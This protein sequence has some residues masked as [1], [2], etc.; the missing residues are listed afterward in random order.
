MMDLRYFRN[1]H[2]GSSI[3]VCGCGESATKIQSTNLIT[4]GIGDISKVFS[5]NYLLISNYLH[6]YEIERSKFILTS[7]ARY[8]FTPLKYIDIDKNNII[9][10]KCGEFTGTELAEDS[11]NYSETSAYMAICL[12]EYMGARSIGVLG[13]DF[14]D[15]HLSGA[16]RPHALSSQVDKIN[17]EFDLLNQALRRRG[18]NVYNLSDVSKIQ[19]FERASWSEF[20]TK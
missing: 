1:I 16:N 8:I 5:P 9:Y 6:Q 14:T 13:V 10:A 18:I 7:T 19:A 17:L 20:I 12:A 11:L 2:R 3:I 15:R 4:I